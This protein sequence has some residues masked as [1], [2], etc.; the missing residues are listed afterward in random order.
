MA[1]DIQYP[2]GRGSLRDVMDAHKTN[3]F[4]S[5]NCVLIGK[6]ESYDPLL[7]T[8]S[9]S[10]Q[11]TRQIYGEAEPTTFDVLTDCPV[12]I[13]QGG[14]SWLSMPITKGDPCIILF[15]DRDIDNWWHDGSVTTPASLRSH[16]LSDGMVLVG[17][18]HRKSAIAVDNTLVELHGG[19][20]KVKTTS[21]AGIAERI[22]GTGKYSVK[23]NAADLKTQLDALCDAVSNLAAG[24]YIPGTGPLPTTPLS[25]GVAVQASVSAIK[26]AIGTLLEAG[27]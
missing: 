10:I 23:N 3:I 12:F 6:I 22:N 25:T 4:K 17:I 26:T 19:A 21:S 8:A 18:Q 27:S 13:V 20:K 14:G 2:L 9:V 11:H 16:S 1:Q 7:N 24:L 15:S 5:M